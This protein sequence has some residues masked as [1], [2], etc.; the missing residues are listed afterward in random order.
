LDS[1]NR[2]I[3]ND[4]IH[5]TRRST[6]NSGGGPGPADQHAS[7][8]PG[9][10]RQHQI[11][12][13]RRQLTASG[14]RFPRNTVGLSSADVAGQRP[15]SH[16]Y[17]GIQHLPTRPRLLAPARSVVAAAAAS[18]GLEH[19]DVIVKLD[20]SE[21]LGLGLLDVIDSKAPVTGSPSPLRIT[22]SAHYHGHAR[23]LPPYVRARSTRLPLR[24][25]CPSCAPEVPLPHLRPRSRSR[26]APAARRRS[27]PAGPWISAKSLSAKPSSVS[28]ASRARRSRLLRSHRC[29]R[30]FSLE[31]PRATAGMSSRSSCESVTTTGAL[32]DPVDHLVG[33][34]LTISP[35]LVLSSSARP[36]ADARRRTSSPAS[37]LAMRRGGLGGLGGGRRRSSLR[38]AGPSTTSSDAVFA[39]AGLWITP[40]RA[41]LARGRGR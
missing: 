8:K 38:S 13:T 3:S 17:L 14:S 26:P 25:P 15:C 4:S 27:S 32:V 5:T 33:P 11:R 16:A 24:L 29:K 10:R 7:A 19:G 9:Y 20:A 30:A 22:S 21:R 37:L 6:R 34:G 35:A 12:A 2:S 28:F 23:T 1:P 40:P 36:S 31:A 39:E 41:L 18:G